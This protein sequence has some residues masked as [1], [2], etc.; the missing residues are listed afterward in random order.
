MVTDNGS[1][2]PKASSRRRGGLSNMQTRASLIGATFSATVSPD[3]QG[4]RLEITLPES[5]ADRSPTT[6]DTCR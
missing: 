5:M 4:T 1:G 3:G 2:L 6:T